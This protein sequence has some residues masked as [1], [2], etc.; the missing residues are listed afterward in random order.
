MFRS[1][2]SITY[3]AISAFV[4]MHADAD[5]QGL[6]QGMIT[7]MRGLCNGLGPAMFG[8]VFSLFHVDLSEKSAASDTSVQT[9]TSTAE[10]EANNDTVMEV[11]QSFLMV[12]Q[13]VP[14]PPFVFGALLVIVAL[15]VAAFI[16]DNMGREHGSHNSQGSSGRGDRGTFDNHSDHSTA[17]KRLH[18][19]NHGEVIK[20]SDDDFDDYDGDESDGEFRIPLMDSAKGGVL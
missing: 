10:D 1:Y 15:M 17:S 8:L 7:G 9:G 19:D 2:F 18:R 4:S 11:P 5:K 6:V 16:P 13:I 12:A 20:K 14:G 3:P